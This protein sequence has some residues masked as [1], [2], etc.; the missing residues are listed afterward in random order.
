MP[1]GK[2][3]RRQSPLAA[4]RRWYAN[5]RAARFQRRFGLAEQIGTTDRQHLLAVSA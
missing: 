2:R 1:D 3:K 4:K 5:Y